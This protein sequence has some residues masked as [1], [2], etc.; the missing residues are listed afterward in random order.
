MP[1]T[2]DSLSC[3]QWLQ[4]PRSA[5]VL[6]YGRQCFR[7]P[8]SHAISQRARASKRT[9]SYRV[10]DWF[11]VYQRRS[12]RHQ[13]K[14]WG[15]G[16]TS[17]LP[18]L[19]LRVCERG[20]RLSAG[21]QHLKSETFTFV[22]PPQGPSPPLNAP[23]S[24]FHRPVATLL[25]SA[26]LNVLATSQFPFTATTF[27]FWLW[28]IHLA[29]SEPLATLTSLA[30]SSSTTWNCRLKLLLIRSGGMQRYKRSHIGSPHKGGKCARA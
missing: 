14:G 22:P 17:T 26:S 23:H 7:Q 27:P 19:S 20:L 28:L 30:Q 25:C 16:D 4:L 24:H 21:L 11:R 2:P 1:W 18:V 10:C 12:S 6:F 29:L 3:S 5:T 13:V 8:S 15:P 9:T